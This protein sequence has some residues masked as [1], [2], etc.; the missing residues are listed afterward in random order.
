LPYFI[1]EAAKREA[2]S[3]SLGPKLPHVY[4]ESGYSLRRHIDLLDK[5][6]NFIT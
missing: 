4:L 3:H 5:V 2:F 1:F 6:C